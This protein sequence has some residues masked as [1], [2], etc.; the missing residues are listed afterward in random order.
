MIQVKEKWGGGAVLSVTKSKQ[1]VDGQEVNRT[2]SDKRGVVDGQLVST[3]SYQFK[4]QS[5]V[6]F[7]DVNI[8]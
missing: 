5:L 3:R 4:N 2:Q 8:L 7:L 1:R 6:I